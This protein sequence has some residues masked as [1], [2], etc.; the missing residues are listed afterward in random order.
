MLSI[1]ALDLSIQVSLHEVI[2]TFSYA[3]NILSYFADLSIG[4]V[5]SIFKDRKTTI[6][7]YKHTY[8]V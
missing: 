5:H 4:S 1:M 2:H 7:F 8:V 6:G 3:A